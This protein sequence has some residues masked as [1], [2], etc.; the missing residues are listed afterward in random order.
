M[1]RLHS[2][3]KMHAWQ[4]APPVPHDPFDSPAYG[5]QVPLAVQHPLGHV[6]ASQAQTPMPVSQRPLVH[7]VHAAPAVPHCAA[8]SEA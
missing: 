7:G 3:P 4:A 2:C 8:D 6:F 5:S 1:I